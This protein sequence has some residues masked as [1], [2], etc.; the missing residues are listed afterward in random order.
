MK[1]STQQG[2][3]HY[4]FSTKQG[5]QHKKFSTQEGDQHYNFSKEQ[6]Y[7]NCILV[8]DRVTNIRNLKQDKVIIFILQKTIIL[9]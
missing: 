9:F 3:E 7:Q 4:K 5:S 6:G 8:L 1:F 2:D